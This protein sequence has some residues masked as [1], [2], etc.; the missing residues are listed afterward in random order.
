[1]VTRFLQLP[2]LVLALAA[3]CAFAEGWVPTLAPRTNLPPQFMAVD[4]GRQRAFL[5][6]SQDGALRTLQSMSCTTGMRGGGKLLEGDRK[7]PEGVYFLQGKATGGLDFDRF[8]NTAYPLNYPNPADRVLGK[9]GDGIMI[10][11]RGRTFGPRQT[12][13]CV[14]LENDVV[15][16]LDRHVR[17]QA[18]PVVIAD[19][20]KWGETARFG[21]PPEIVMGTKGWVKARERREGAFFEIY[22]PERFEKSSGM[23]FE[24]FK[25]KTLQEFSRSPWVD[26]RMQDLQVLEGPGYMVSAFAERTYPQGEEGWRRLYWMRKVELW[27]IVGEEWVPR[28]LGPRQDYATLAGSEIRERLRQCAEAWDRGDLKTLIQAYDR[29]ASRGRDQGR[30]AIA[31]A[32]DKERGKPNPFR[33]EPSVRVTKEGVEA[34]LRPAG[35]QT[36]TFLFLPGAFDAWVISREE[37]AS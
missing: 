37:G 8:G 31:A 10:H 26:I 1:M 36:R 20:V 3:S 6:R 2:V 25:R 21:P 16:R 23:N 27:K 11:G 19:G 28:N 4:M 32:L 29:T 34:V 5:L 7:T 9:T 22:D 24:Q 18:S 15:D 35:G 33:A 14:V 17:I 12:L 30:D 13:G